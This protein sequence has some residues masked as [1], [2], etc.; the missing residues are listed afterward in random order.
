MYWTSSILVTSDLINNTEEWNFG[1]V[2]ATFYNNDILKFLHDLRNKKK[3]K[4]S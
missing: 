2:R 1:N 4:L 3:V